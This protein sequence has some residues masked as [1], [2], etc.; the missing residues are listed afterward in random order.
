MKIIINI[1][2]LILNQIFKKRYWSYIY[3]Y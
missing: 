2:K 3:H 1:A